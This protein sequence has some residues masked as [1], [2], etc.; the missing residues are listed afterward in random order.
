MYGHEDFDSNARKRFEKLSSLKEL[1]I[2][3][4]Q[5]IFVYMKKKIRSNENVVTIFFYLI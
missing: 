3:V 4:R 5:S 1:K 2:S